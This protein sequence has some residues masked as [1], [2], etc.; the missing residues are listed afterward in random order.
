MFLC[1]LTKEPKIFQK[2][3]KPLQKFLASE[4]WH[5]ENSIIRNLIY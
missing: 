4:W 5:E 3:Y 1:S 2:I